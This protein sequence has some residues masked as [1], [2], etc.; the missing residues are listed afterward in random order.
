MAVYEGRALPRPG[1]ELV[2][3]GLAFDLE[4]VARRRQVLRAFG[5]GAV[6]L[7]LGACGD[8]GDESGTTAGTT[9]TGLSEIPDETA[10]PYPGDGSNGPNVLTESGVIRKDIRSSFGE[11][12]GTAEGVPITLSLTI[13]DLAKSGAAFAGVAV[14]VWHCNRAGEYSLYSAGITAEN[15]LRG[16]Q[17]ADSAG[18]VE[19]TSIF[20]ACYSGRWPHIHFEVYPDQA[21][22]SDAAKAIATSQIALPKV[23]CDEVYATTGYESSVTNLQQVTLDSDNVF[24]EDSG[25]T[26]LATVTGDATTGFAVALEVGVDTTTTPTG[27]Q[28]TG[29]G[30]PSG[31]PPGGGPGGPPSGMPSGMPPGGGAPPS[32]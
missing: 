7:G 31:A 24:G 2:D 9:E 8:D 29:D 10:G 23:N 1:E 12:S 11:A 15:Y 3:Q 22:I 19:F 4:T 27:G 28:N 32:R 14:Y 18:K 30:A 20:P 21:S 5:L 17:I 25:V 26:Q 16:V 13:K 6:A